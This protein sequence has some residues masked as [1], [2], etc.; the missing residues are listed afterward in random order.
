MI[1]MRLA[2]LLL[3]L[4][5]CHGGGP[6]DVG[7]RNRRSTFA[8][9]AGGAPLTTIDAGPPAIAKPEVRGRRPRLL[10]KATARALSLRGPLV[11]YG[12]AEEDGLFSVPKAGGLSVRVGPRAP[13]ANGLATAG[14][15]VVWIGSP[16][17]TVLRLLPTG[18]PGVVRE[19]GIFTHVAAGTDVWLTEAHGSAGA[20][21]MLGGSSTAS[22]DSPPRGLTADAEHAFV[23]TATQLL[24]ATRGR[25]ELAPLAEG[26]ALA[27]PVASSD[28]IY[29]T[30]ASGTGRALVRVPKTGGR[31]EAIASAVRDA[32]IACHADVV[33]WIDAERPAL[34]AR[35]PGDRAPRVLS[36]DESFERA[37]AIAVDD[38]SVV[39]ATGTSD[40]GRIQIVPLR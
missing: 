19:G 3:V 17:S 4:V 33:Y 13:V 20:L 7:N 14:A 35:G 40:D 10:L 16:G 37:V 24:V 25:G 5:A 27:S 2:V 30:A 9:G 6:P 34:L 8:D 29:L 23:A 28:S 15:D 21:V 11:F 18:A 38:E 22:F 26:E 32:P 1:A 39:L 36:E 31:L 12:D